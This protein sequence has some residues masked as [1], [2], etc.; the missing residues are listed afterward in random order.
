LQQA[1]TAQA[2]TEAAAQATT[3]SGAIVDQPAGADRG[4]N[5]GQGAANGVGQGITAA[6]T[7]NLTAQAFDCATDLAEDTVERSA[8]AGRVADFVG[9]AFAITG[10]RPLPTLL[11]TE[12]RGL[13]WWPGS[14][15][16]RAW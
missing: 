7:G 1:G 4:A 14:G 12:P 13:W 10:T 3:G 5:V 9:G 11:V 8:E 15:C 16:R 6:G 2:A